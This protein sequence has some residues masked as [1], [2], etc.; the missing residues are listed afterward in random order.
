M[1]DDGVAASGVDDHYSRSRVF[2]CARGLDR[3]D[4][5][6][7]RSPEECASTA[8][9]K[10]KIGASVW[11]S[12]ERMRTVKPVLVLGLFDTL[13]I[14]PVVSNM[15]L[16]MEPRVRGVSYMKDY[17]NASC[18]ECRELIDLRTRIL[19]LEAME[20][21]DTTYRSLL[22][23]LQSIWEEMGES[24]EERDRMLLQLEQECLDV[25][26]WKVDQANCVRAG[27]H[28][29]LADS[30]SE[31]ASLLL[32]LVRE[33]VGQYSAGA[34]LVRLTS[35]RMLASAER[36]AA[37]LR[38]CNARYKGSLRRYRQGHCKRP[39][40]YIIISGM[41]DLSELLATI[42]SSIA[43][44]KEES[45]GR[46]DIMERME[47]WISACEEESWLE[48]YNKDESRFNATRGAHLNLKRAERAR[49]IV[50]K[51]PNLLESLK[52]KTRKRQALLI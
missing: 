8:L 6:I 15:V 10:T 19:I 51:L 27:L 38:T 9:S 25:Y 31:L 40:M 45:L 2:M 37:D 14:V 32:L 52:S 29:L 5:E 3:I 20:G 1:H 12:L 47:R 22:R 28:Q 33:E 35:V 16:R 39:R 43:E 13:K 7:D 44:A 17:G 34:A 30:E 18:K 50:A 46:Q 49:V 23:E 48:E 11:I 41:V 24:D 36:G 4:E 21:E 42:E 26:R